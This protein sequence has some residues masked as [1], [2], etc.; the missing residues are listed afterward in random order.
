MMKI[1]HVTQGYA[2][3]IGGTEALVQHLSEEL[4]RDYRDQVTVFTT[5]CYNGEAFFK[6]NLP[7][8]PIGWE[9][10]N[11]VRVRRFPVRRRVSQ[12]SRWPQRIAT[13]LG[14]P[15]NEY[16]R[17]LS[18]GPV[19]SGLAKAIREFPADV[20]AASSFPLMHM[21][22]ALDAAIKS[23]RACVFY[24]G[25]H[26]QDRWGFGRPMIYE[27]IRK[28]TAYVAYTDFE[29]QYVV[30]QGIPPER[31]SVIGIGVDPKPFE[32]I[33]ALEA[34][35]RLGLEGKPVVA[36]IGQLGGHKGVDTL[37]R[38]MP[39]VWQVVPEA[40]ILIAGART[41][42]VDYLERVIRRWPASDQAKLVRCY[43]FSEEAKPELFAA[44][45]VIAYPSGYESFGITFLEAWASGKP[46]IGCHRGAV[47]WVVHAGRDGLLVK[48]QKEKELA[49][50][51]ILLLKNPD[52]A[53]TLGEA[54]RQKVLARY[55][56]P[57]IAR[58]FRQVYAE[59]IERTSCKPGARTLLRPS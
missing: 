54:G 11:G 34:K 18:G 58:R 32:R 47:P 36:F 10:I 3:A 15:F 40:H 55:T 9:E 28:A 14:L 8:L 45:D 38:A 30:E 12:L 46:V 5:N 59:A 29:A 51:I 21:Y 2:P 48:Y 6:P 49:E 37:V 42:F 39:L 23:Q 20:I 43:N 16:L 35:Q 33:S 57:E 52:W 1:L 27:A 25:L 41:L 22:V 50:A 26:P 13:R 17:T 24:G 56:W 53:S 31:I 44:A 4:V 19:I 7:S